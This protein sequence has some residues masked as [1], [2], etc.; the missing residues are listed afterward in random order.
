MI[1]F[2]E[3][4]NEMLCLANRQGYFT[5]V[6]QAWTRTLGWSTEEI[7][8]RP[9]VDFVHPE[10]LGATI[11]E[12]TMLQTGS[13]ETI[14][15]ENRYLCKD[16][17]FKWLAWH[18]KLEPDSDQLVAAAR[19]V[20][21]QK[22]QAEALR[23]SEERFRH[24]ATNAP[25]GIF[26]TDLQPN[27]LFVNE[28]WCEM[29]GLSSELALG[30]GWKVAVHPD[31]QQRIFLAWTDA[32]RQG[33]QYIDEG[34]FLKPNGEIVWIEIAA[35]PYS[36]LE[37]KPVS[38]IGTTV[39]ITERI[40][41]MATITAEQN[42]LQQSIDLQDHERMLIAY[43]IHDGLIQ[44]ATGA[45]LH[46]LGYQSTVASPGN[47]ELLDNAI[48]ALRQTVAEGRRVMN[49]IRT[50]VLDEHGVTAAIEEF[51]LEKRTENT[52][53]E[54]IPPKKEIGRFS[55]ERE[56]AIYRMAQEAV[57]NALKHS[58]SSKIRVTLE[59]FN[60]CIQLTVK[61]WG[62]GI[63]QKNPS[64]GVHGL[65]GI[66]ERVRLLNGTFQLDSSPGQG[67]RITIELPFP[68][69]TAVGGS[70]RY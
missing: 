58:Q 56:I 9:Y 68:K 23:E 63:A 12:A 54:F 26:L 8:S 15:F 57:N 67:T 29:S 51:V 61:D 20:T 16:G 4:S 41:A 6:N 44:Y 70:N 13:H 14:Q 38:Y 69:A 7:M 22:A 42:L 27:C 49:G 28:R 43:D 35:A 32:V 34:R 53:I 36:N 55:A 31:D 50:P 46:L 19:D 18:A 45:L 66:K 33:K 52:E 17:S 5:R 62:V 30:D 48:K 24:L 11:R 2:F 39:D 1:D 59:Q 64:R 65:L 21:Q 3:F 47:T 25:V 40:E 37:G 60:N 10:D